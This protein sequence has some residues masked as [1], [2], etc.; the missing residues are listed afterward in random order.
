MKISN[1][2]CLE[3]MNTFGI[4]ATAAAFAEIHSA[5]DLRIVLQANAAEENLPIQILGGGS[6]VLFLKEFYDCLFLK[7]NIGGI[8]P[9]T[10]EG[11][12]T[13]LVEI[14]GGVNWHDFVL[15]TIENDL[16]GV[17][18]LSLIPGTVGAAPIQNIGA[19]GVELKDVFV[20]LEA[21]D[22]QTLDN[23]TFM[24]ADSQFG[25]RDSVFK[26]ELKG[27][28]FIT[29]VVLK[30]QAVS[31]KLQADGVYQVNTNYGDIKKTLQERHIE[32]PT[33]RD[34]SDAVISIRQAKLPDPKV[35]GNAGSFFKNPEIS[36]P[37]FDRL[38]TAFPKIVGYPTASGAVKVAAA[39]LIEACGWKG[40]RFGEV[41][42]HERQALVLVN[43]GGGKGLEIKDLA[44]KIQLSVLGKFGITLTAE[45]NFV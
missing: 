22:L 30:L 41:G 7:N 9:Q 24:S 16:G 26:K 13:V 21:I 45:V 2:L 20:R 31:H 29:Q 33:I 11:G 35:I 18:N 42:V 28:F 34:V 10:P 12:L 5:D 15:W 40:K 32:T 27:K 19:Y 8:V 6:N 36:A 44:E 25:Y 17:E 14:G 1:N 23:Q 39:W 43:Y 3:K 4:A 38:K 37:H